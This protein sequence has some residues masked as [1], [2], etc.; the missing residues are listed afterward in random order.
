MQVG[1]PEVLSTERPDGH[2]GIK[3]DGG[4]N[5]ASHLWSFSF[6]PA[7]ADTVHRFSR[8]CQQRFCSNARP[9]L[10]LATRDLAPV[11][12]EPAT[13][14]DTACVITFLMTTNARLALHG[15]RHDNRSPRT[16]LRPRR[17]GH[18]RRRVGNGR[19]HIRHRRRY[20][21]HELRKRRH[22]KADDRRNS[23]SAQKDSHRHKILPTHAL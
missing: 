16:K 9:T 20:A 21:R 12:A 4:C 3:G 19:R 23:N 11:R 22:R 14:L 8:R 6:C 1:D 5:R 13:G 7:I 10:P 2:D 17:V 15:R 18:G